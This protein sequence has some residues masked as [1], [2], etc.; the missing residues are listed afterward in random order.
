M[1]KLITSS[2]MILVTVLMTLAHTNPKD[3][4]IFWVATD[5]SNKEEP[6]TSNHLCRVLLWMFDMTDTPSNRAWVM[7]GWGDGH[8][9][10]NNPRGDL[11]M[12][13]Q[14][15]ETMKGDLLQTLTG[16]EQTRVLSWVTNNYAIEADFTKTF[17]DSLASYGITNKPRQSVTE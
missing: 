9:K 15:I 5:R 13:N 11:V 10:T 6:A 1:K 12:W 2:L 3:Y 7:E 4:T 17:K 14:T 8:Y 16:P